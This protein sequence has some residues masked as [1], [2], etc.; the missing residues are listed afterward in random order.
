MITRRT[1]E[2]F[3]FNTARYKFNQCF[4]SFVLPKARLVNR[5][6]YIILNNDLLVDLCKIVVY[7]TCITIQINILEVFLINKTTIG[8]QKNLL[9]FI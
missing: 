3:R 4:L 1:N 2:K 8:K 7:W 9:F 6:I 5:I